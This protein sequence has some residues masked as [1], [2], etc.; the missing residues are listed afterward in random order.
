MLSW[1]IQLDWF[2]LNLQIYL[3]VSTVTL[4]LTVKVVNDF[5]NL[6]D[7]MIL[8]TNHWIRWLM[9]VSCY[10]KPAY[11][12]CLNL[13]TQFLIKHRL[14]HLACKGIVKNKANLPV[15]TGPFDIFIGSLSVYRLIGNMIQPVEPSQAAGNVA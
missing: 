14:W 9:S 15:G 10:K 8:G 3:L 12:D 6:F 7:S 2:S 4:S 11:P 13:T 1:M 5:V